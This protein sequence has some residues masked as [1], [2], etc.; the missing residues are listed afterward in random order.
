MGNR[1]SFDSVEQI[2]NKQ[3]GKEIW[4][5]WSVAV[6]ESYFLHQRRRSSNINCSQASWVRSS[7]PSSIMYLH[8]E[9]ANQMCICPS[10]LLNKAKRV[11]NKQKSPNGI[12]VTFMTVNQQK[13]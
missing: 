13:N 6:V 12:I 8:N 2:K 10:C 7:H 11:N 4:D 3:N 1:I 5:L 9:N